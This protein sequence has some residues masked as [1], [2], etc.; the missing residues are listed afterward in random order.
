MFER[1]LLP[2][3]GSEIAEMILPYG[4]EL[5]RRLGAE[6][7]LFHIRGPEHQQDER[8]HQ[9]YLDR[10]AN[11]VKRNIRKRWRKGTEA[12][13]TTIVEAGELPEN[14]CNLV[15]KTDVGLIIMAAVSASGL[16]VGK[17]LGSVTDH[18]CRTVPVPVMLIRPQGIE[19]TEGKK[20]LIN[21]ILLP[22]DGSDLSKRALP[23]GEELAVKLKVPI[24]LFQ[25]AHVIYPYGGE[26]A[27]FVDYEKFSEDE[28]RRVRG[29]IIALEKELRE[30]GL[31]VTHSVT[32][33]T[34][35]AHE[36]L[37]AGK[38]VGADL[39]VMSTHGR[40]GLRRWVLGSVTEK[41]LRHGEIPLLLVN[42]RAG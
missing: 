6:V 24:T 1:I 30:K 14:I 39:V 17:M 16:K 42:V 3:D 10:L 36:I 9:M 27:P 4:E 8:M 21:R 25:M 28:A 33:G 29:E 11:T 2:L 15:D 5:A 23:V 22:L 31:T 32:S 20:R 13:V 40:S 35:A 12:K 34:D 18:V 7:I 38:K 41:V 37:E 26:P 19:R